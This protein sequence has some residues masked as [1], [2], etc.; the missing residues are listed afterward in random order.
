MS[1]SVQD[2]PKEPYQA[3]AKMHLKEEQRSLPAAEKIEILQKKDRSK[4]WHVGINIAAVLFFGYSFYFGIT[5]L[6]DTILYILLAVF[7][8][9]V[10]LI[11]YQKK[12][13]RQLIAHLK[14]ETEN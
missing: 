12:Q 7:G 5:Q 6:S 1:S 4:W 3:Y 9:N 2:Q 10:G 11:F 13:I 14:R 8:I